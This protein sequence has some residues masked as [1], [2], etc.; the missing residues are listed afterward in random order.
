MCPIIN[1]SDCLVKGDTIL[2]SCQ[3]STAHMPPP[4]C[5]PHLGAH[6][7]GAVSF[8]PLPIPF[9]E[10]RYQTSRQGSS[11]SGACQ[12]ALVLPSTTNHFQCPQ[13]PRPCKGVGTMRSSLPAQAGLQGSAAIPFLYFLGGG[14]VALVNQCATLWTCVCG[15]IAISWRKRIREGCVNADMTDTDHDGS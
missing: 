10:L 8:P 1:S 3:L 2:L 5:P 11:P 7:F 13:P 12:G 6:S 14:S 15:S 4:P 9:L